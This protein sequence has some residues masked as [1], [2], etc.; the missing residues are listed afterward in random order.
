MAE[1]STKYVALISRWLKT[2]GVGFIIVFG[3]LIL[4]VIIRDHGKRMGPFKPM[5][6][7]AKV[8]DL[9]FDQVIKAPDKYLN[10]HV[11]WCVQNRSKSEV[12]YR[13]DSNK[14]LFVF[15]HQQMPLEFGSK[16]SSCADMLLQI[17]GARQ[18]T[19]S[20]SAVGVMFILAF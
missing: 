16:H 2:V 11:I 18:N 6:T 10:K 9:S 7:E 3:S 4:T 13:G 14:N 15:N 1:K 12:N 17:K 8:L 19:T 5:I 20:S